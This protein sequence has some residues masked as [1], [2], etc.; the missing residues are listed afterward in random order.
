MNR[1]RVFTKRNIPWFYRADLLSRLLATSLMRD[2]SYHWQ[3]D[4]WF[5]S[6]PAFLTLLKAFDGAEEK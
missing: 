3:S 5:N 1:S 2:R 4:R 6:I